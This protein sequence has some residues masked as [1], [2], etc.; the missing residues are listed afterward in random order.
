[1]RELNYVDSIRRQVLRMVAS[2]FMNAGNVGKT[3]EEIPFEIRPKDGMHNR[4]CVFKDR[5]ILRYRIMAAMGLLPDDEKDDHTPLREYAE[6]VQERDN[7]FEHIERGQPR[8]VIASC[9]IACHGCV[10][11]RYFVTNACQ[12]CVAHPCTSACRFGAVSIVNGKSQIDIKK[13]RNCSK[14]KGA[15]PYEAIVQISVPCEKA[16]PVSCI[17][18]NDTDGR[19]EI[20]LAKCTSCGRCMRAC[21]FGAML[22]RS[23][24]VDVINQ[25]RCERHLTALV[26]P[27]IAGQFQASLP[28]IFG[29]LKKLGFTEVLE[30][31]SGADLTSQHEA[32]EF[33]EHLDQGRAFMTTSCCPAYM[34]AARKLIPELMPFVS[35]TP[36]PMHYTAEL[37]LEKFPDTVPV[38]V[39][40]CVAKRVERLRDNIV[41]HVLTFE[42]LGALFE[43]AGIVPENCP[44]EALGDG[45]SPEGRRYAVTSGVA[46]AVQARVGDKLAVR[47]VYINGLSDKQIHQLRSFAASGACPGN[48]VEVMACEG[49]CVNGGGVLADPERSARAV[50]GFAKSEA[51][52]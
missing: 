41:K 38:F 42:E 13:C 26:A 34:R 12:G 15:C 8:Y 49:G 19:A 23:E 43:A 6:R 2:A 30:V 11:A 40:P 3:V 52:S 51:A 25:I 17:K 1:M 37:A 14:C 7:C 18:K 9:D 33:V 44:E 4:C 36:T 48:L 28:K 32:S 46:S 16:C 50:D 27:A 22:E 20:D 29:A 10:P 5:A 45:A 21:P 24:I 47:P 35:K 31:A 39:G